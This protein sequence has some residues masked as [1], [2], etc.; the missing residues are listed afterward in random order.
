LTPEVLTQEGEAPLSRV[1]RLASPD[2]VIPKNS[3][4]DYL[5]ISRRAN[6]I[7][8]FRVTLIQGRRQ[9]LKNRL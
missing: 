9:L 5:S 4:S 7:L 2:N 3:P 1:Y 6:K 8:N